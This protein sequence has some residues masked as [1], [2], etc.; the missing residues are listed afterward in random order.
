KTANSST[1]TVTA[2]A[3]ARLQL[4]LPGESAAAGTA[5]GKTGTPTSPIAAG[6]TFSVTVNAV[7][8]YWNIVSSV[9]DT[10]GFSSTDANA[11]LPANTALVAGTTT[12]SVL[13][14][15]AGSRTVTVSDVTDPSKTADTSPAVT[16]NAGAAATLTVVAPASVPSG[17][18]F[19]VTVTAKDAYGNLAVGY[20]GTVHLTTDDAAA[21]LPA[22]S[23]FVSG[24]AGVRSISGVVL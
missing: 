12:R 8:A 9:T 7:D 17:G 20:L 16:V 5:T 21:T 3:F 19:S 13:F 24:D 6:T 18:A 14:K 1:L 4:L 22:D 2:A 10:V 23:T 11:S 15:T